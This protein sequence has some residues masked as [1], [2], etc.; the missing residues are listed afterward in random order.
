MYIVKYIHILFDF[1]LLKNE[2]IFYQV[3]LKYCMHLYL[4]KICI[5]VTVFLTN[6]ERE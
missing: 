5:L 6:I 2:T 4:F 3:F 1:Y